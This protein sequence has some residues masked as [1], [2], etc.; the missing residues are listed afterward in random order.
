ML[1]GLLLFA[2]LVPASFNRAADMAQ[3]DGQTGL[4]SRSL[5]TWARQEIALG[6]YG[7]TVPTQPQVALWGLCGAFL[8]INDRCAAMVLAWPW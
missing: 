3:V 5:L 7:T 6:V 1:V 2:I 8:A 4:T